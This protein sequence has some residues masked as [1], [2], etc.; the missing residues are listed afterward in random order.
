L[1]TFRGIHHIVSGATALIRA[2]AAALI[3]AA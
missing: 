1:V 3:R 2:L